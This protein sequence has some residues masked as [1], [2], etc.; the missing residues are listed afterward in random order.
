MRIV[1]S[2]QAR[3]DLREIRKFIGR[4]APTTANSYVRRLKSSVD[5]LRIFPES[6]NVVREV[7]SPKIREIYF[8]QYRIIYELSPNRVEVLT[9]FHGARLLDETQF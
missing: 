3:D 8:G 5:R 6:G 1:W 7:G 9:V 4:D 2:F